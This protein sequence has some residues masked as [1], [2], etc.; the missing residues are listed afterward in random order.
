MAPIH[1]TLQYVEGCP[2][3][4][5]VAAVLAELADELGD[6]AV[7]YER[8]D[9]EEQARRAGFAGSPTVL[10]DGVDPFAAGEPATGL[11]CRRYATPHGPRGHPDREQLRAALSKR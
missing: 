11:A 1:V 9:S 10:V 3:A 2:N 5:E 7:R 6:L 8:I 4:R